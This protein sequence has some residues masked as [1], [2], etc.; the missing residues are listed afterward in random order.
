VKFRNR[1]EELARLNEAWDRA[2]TGEPQLVLV[3]GRRRVG[4]S[5]LLG[6]FAAGCRSIV[7]VATREAMP[8]QLAALAQSIAALA[9][10]GVRP[11][12]DSWHDVFSVANALAVDESL[13]LVLDEVPYLQDVDSAWATIAQ[14][15]WDRIS[16]GRATKLMVVLSGSSR[17]VM[18]SLTGGGGPLY[19][20]AT[21]NLRV[22]PI[23][24]EDVGEFLPDLTATQRFE[25]YAATGGYPMHLN[26][27][28]QRR[29]TTQNLQT[30]AGS[31]GA[32]LYD[33]ARMI[34]AEEFPSGVG[35]ERVLASI[36]VGRRRFGEISSDAGI[37]IE[38]PLDTLEHIGLVEAERPIG[39]P[40]KT[41]P[42]YRIT[43][44]YLAFWFNVLA[45]VRGPIEMG[46]GAA[47]LRSSQAV[48]QG[49]IAATFED[50]SRRYLAK[51]VSQE[52]LPECAIGR[53]WGRSGR[54]VDVEIDAVGLHGGACVLAAEV[55]WQQGRI[56]QRDLNALSEKAS[57]VFGE[58][59][60]R[61]LVS[62]TRG[63]VDARADNSGL[64]VTLSDMMGGE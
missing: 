22:N 38:A 47:A 33:N 13:L 56:V 15:A 14:T 12:I 6:H 59:D 62:V 50:A 37:R 36:G 57:S 30:L 34:L 25:A 27:W 18:E 5:F 17:R 24:P 61:F 49:H 60:D 9:S 39:S 21:Q 42:L 46:T 3:T 2:R 53:W 58:R 10:P 23:A 20:R 40:R 31:P 64:H 16:H 4:K 29:S 51:L 45:R 55:K 43:D 32:L 63:E 54:G 11:A 44:P 7:H 41:H 19:G 48:W 52:L 35:Y 8:I 1:T 28:D 26:A